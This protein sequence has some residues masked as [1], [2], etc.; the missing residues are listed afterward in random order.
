M[1]RELAATVARL[2]TSARFSPVARAVLILPFWFVLSGIAIVAS[3]PAMAPQ[4]A[5]PGRF[6]LVSGIAQALATLVAVWGFRRLLDRASLVSLGLLPASL[7][8]EALLGALVGSA[9]I[10]FVVGVLWLLGAVAFSPAPAIAPLTLAGVLVGAAIA[11]ADFLWLAR[12]LTAPPTARRRAWALATG[13]RWLVLLG[14]LGAALASR[15]VDA[16][17][18]VVGL[19]VLPAVVVA[20]GLRA[21]RR[22]A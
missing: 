3:L 8:R 9:A 7:W 1:H 12:G 6:L 4:A 15:W 21:A 2:R 14:A 18:L 17:A 5:G 22:D 20:A 19:V 16:R 13:L 10:L 11:L